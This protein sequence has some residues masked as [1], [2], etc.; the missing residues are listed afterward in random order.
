MLDSCGF[1]IQ[2]ATEKI[3]RMENSYISPLDT[4]NAY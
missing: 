4:Q 3:T 1:N 2:L